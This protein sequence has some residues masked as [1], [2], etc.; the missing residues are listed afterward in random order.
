MLGKVIVHGPDREAARR[1]LVAALDDTAILGLTTNLGFLRALAA[2]DEFRDATIDTAWLDH[3]RGRSRPTPSCR[4]CSPPGRWRCWRPSTPATRSR[5]TASGRGADPAPVLVELDRPVLV[6]RAA[7]ERRR[8]RCTSCAANHA[9]V[10][11][12]RQRRAGRRQ[13]AAHAVEVV[14]RGQR[15]VFDRPDAFADHAA[16]VGDGA[17]TAPM[18]GTV[19]A[20][21]VAAGDAVAEGEVLGVMEAMKMELALKAPFAGTVDDGRRRGRR[22]G[23]ARRHAVRGEPRR[24]CRR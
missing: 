1:A 14:H 4:A 3:A 12:R 9:V 8:A 17:V 20:V 15:F 5:P 7:V 2:S 24:S 10:L 13:R 21:R 16:A 6:D 22:A 23:G 19:L 11:R 18:P